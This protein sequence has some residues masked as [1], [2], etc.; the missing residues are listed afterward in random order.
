MSTRY[1]VEGGACSI[2]RN[3]P[4]VLA[5]TVWERTTYV[6]SVEGLGQCT[7]A[8]PARRGRWHIGDSSD[9]RKWPSM[10][11]MTCVASLSVTTSASSTGSTE[12]ESR[13]KKPHQANLQ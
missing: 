13:G 2:G 5:L 9:Y 12:V 1:A 8:L 3:K 6:V 11:G 10:S 4:D 7:F